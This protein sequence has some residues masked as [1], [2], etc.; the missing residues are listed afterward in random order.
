MV[1]IAD[2]MV[3]VL[4]PIDTSKLV[5]ADVDNFAVRTRQQM[6]EEHLMMA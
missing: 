1:T 6:L 3:A 5:P 2:S 4:P